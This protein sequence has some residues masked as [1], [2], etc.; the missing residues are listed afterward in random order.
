MK[1]A[2][3]INNRTNSYPVMSCRHSFNNQPPSKLLLLWA[4]DNLTHCRLFS[5]SVKCWRSV[6]TVEVERFLVI[7]LLEYAFKALWWSLASR[8]NGFSIASFLAMSRA[9]SFAGVAD[10]LRG[11]GWHRALCVQSL[12][13]SNPPNRAKKRKIHLALSK[14]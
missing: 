13:P 11:P 3:T 8:N 1:E 2:T 12:V 14:I 10:L 6:E 9:S 5:L 4:R 7:L